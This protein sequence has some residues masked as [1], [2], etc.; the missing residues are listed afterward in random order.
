MERASDS[1]FADCLL[2]HAKVHVNRIDGLQRSDGSATRQILSEV[3]LA[4]SQNA[5]EWG[6]DRLALDCGLNLGHIG[7]RRFLLGRGLVII[8]SGDDARFYKALLAFVIQARQVA[9]RLQ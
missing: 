6:P 3:Y 2:R 5:G 8:L 1:D 7:S 4:D 9:L